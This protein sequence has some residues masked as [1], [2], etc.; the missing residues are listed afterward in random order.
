MLNIGIML[1]ITQRMENTNI[2]RK[3]ID[4]GNDN[5]FLDFIHLPLGGVSGFSLSVLIS[6]SDLATNA[7]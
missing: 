4:L 1:H 7:I 2:T 6:D 5:L 3:P